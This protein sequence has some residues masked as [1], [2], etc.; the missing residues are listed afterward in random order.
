M[1]KRIE[2]NISVLG[3]VSVNFQELSTKVYGIYEKEEEVN[4]QKNMPHLGLISKAFSGVN[5]TRYEYVILQCVIS[6]LVENGFK[7]TTSAQGSI[8]IDGD[9][10]SGND[11]LKT[12][13]LL[14]NFGHCKNTFG[15]EKA[16]LLSAISRKGFRS[17]LI[18]SIRDLDLKR[19]AEDVIESLD[20]V[21]FHH[22]ISIGRIY[23]SLKRRVAIQ[24]EI[25]TVYKLLLLNSSETSEICDQLKIEQ[26]KTIFRNIRDLAIISLDSR[27][28]SLPISVD[29][30]S[31]V[32]SFDFYDQRFQQT[33][34]GQL[35]NPI[36]SL[37]MD[38][39]YLHPQS[40][41]HQ[42]AYEVLAID[43]INSTDYSNHISRALQ[44]G[45]ANPENCNLKHFLR[46]SSTL[47]KANVKDNL[48][49][50][51][52]VNRGID[53]VE[54]SLDYNPITNTQVI[55]FYVDRNGFELSAF[56]RFLS[57]IL[58]VL[59]KLG[60]QALDN[61]LNDKQPM[62]KAFVESFKSMGA[63]ANQMQSAFSPVKSAFMKDAEKVMEDMNV[64][65]YRSILWAL[66]K[67]YIKDRYY[68]DIDPHVTDRYKYFGVKFSERFDYLT[69]DID[70]AISDTTNVDRIHELKQLQKSVKRK[71]K[72]NIIAC[73]ARITVYDYSK[74]PSKR[75]V[76]D[77]DGVVLKF[78]QQRMILE[79]HE[80]KNTANPVTD[81]KRDLNTKFVPTLNRNSTGY[82]IKKVTGFGAK[83]VISHES[84]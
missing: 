81:A 5:H 13:F 26:L 3:R 17:H 48:R 65:M 44:S 43:S 28:S 22:L 56:P 76:T 58:G 2:E 71:F 30:L 80:A 67:N 35:F 15:D 82:R 53:N 39:L 41:K 31:T 20:Y 62:L 63:E 9:E 27:N 18:N 21:N 54:A 14:S 57:N 83:L 50:V 23:Q 42:R 29:I 79:L 61:L 8:K 11:I 74:P 64:P 52:T 37:L 33:T 55:D 72:G 73:L 78:N 40:Q 10:Y 24:N 60:E 46:V 12:W 69:M 47:H 25:I 68:F 77:I 84:S 1:E 70:E 4:R 45:L 38:N 36:L 75:K 19:W 59:A 49:L 66:L 7:G 32:L 16:L 51:L 34:A 6:E